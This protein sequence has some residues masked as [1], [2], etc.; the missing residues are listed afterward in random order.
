MPR[1]FLGRYKALRNKGVALGAGLSLLGGVAAANLSPAE[2]AP[3][4]SPAA[5]TDMIAAPSQANPELAA[6]LQKAEQFIFLGDTN[7]TD[8]S[9]KRFMARNETMLTL[10]QEGVE[11][12]FIELPTIFQSDIDRLVQGGTRE[13]ISDFLKRKFRFTGIQN[14]EELREA[15]NLTADIIF[16][17]KKNGINPICADLEQGACLGLENVQ[18]PSLQKFKQGLMPRIKEAIE[19]NPKI[20]SFSQEKL[21]AFGKELIEDYLESL[22]E[23]ERT[24]FWEALVQERL[25]ADE[26]IASFIQE[27]AGGQKSAIFYGVEH[28][29]PENG[30]VLT[31]ELGQPI[32]KVVLVGEK[33]AGFKKETLSGW[34]TYYVETSAPESPSD[35]R[36][37]VSRMDHPEI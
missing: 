34:T 8:L 12:L 30:S 22:P 7:H 15:C 4:V 23:E 1:R 19:K 18:S 26:R 11:N 6:M 35:Q 28:G 14:E 9:I 36:P 33:N 3:P 2:A 32:I 16:N 20:T 31:E 27:K 13:E 10:A 29:K 5:A 17:A 24:A 21:A 37:C 25:Q